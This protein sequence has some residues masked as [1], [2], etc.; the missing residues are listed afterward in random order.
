MIYYWQA[1]HLVGYLFVYR[2][3][4]QNLCRGFEIQITDKLKTNKKMSLQSLVS[5]E[6]KLY[7]PVSQVQV[8]KDLISG[9]YHLPLVFTAPV[10]SEV[11]FTL[12]NN[13]Y[14]DLITAANGGDDVAVQSR[15]NY[16][17]NSWLPAVELIRKDVNAVAKG[18]KVIVEQSGFHSTKVEPTSSVIGE[19]MALDA[20]AGVSGS[21]SFTY[22][23]KTKVKKSSFLIIATQ[24]GTAV[25]QDGKKFTITVPPSDKPTE[26]VVLMDTSKKGVVSG[27]NRTDELDVIISSL[28]PAGSSPASNK[29]TVIV[30]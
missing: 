22:D 3:L 27:L 20:E 10:I 12:I 13:T 30:P 2:E 16:Y 23:S 26:V 28:N 1:L 4:N 15:N 5:Q 18:I 29:A 19:K 24:K 8:G 9:Y 11:A 17:D 7:T 14:N 25:D 21:R 6:Y